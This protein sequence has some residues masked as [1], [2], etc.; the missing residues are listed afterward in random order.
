MY[1]IAICDDIPEHLTALRSALM[2]AIPELPCRLREYSD[3]NE[4]LNDCAA[5]QNC[6]ILLLDICMPGENGISVA[7]KIN[8]VSPA[9]QIIFISAYP[10]YALAAYEADHLYFLTKPVRRDQLC[11]AMKRALAR[12]DEQHAARLLLPIKG[13]LRH[14]L[15]L[16]E[17]LYF[18][19]QLHV[20]HAV[21][22]GGVLDSA[23]KLNA[24]EALL[25]PGGFARP[26]NSYLVNLAR[27]SSASRTVVTL[28]DGSTVPVSNQKRAA[29]L[30]ALA[31]SL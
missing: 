13:G 22:S 3:V 30:D 12:I 23:L 14:V 18:E 4:L 1:G 10:A 19:R 11:A 5:G 21:C 31:R 2:E 25:P 20:T 15:R 17:I 24:I 29:F 6:E 16:S 7:Q 26:H 9:T 27:V 28:S 8:Q